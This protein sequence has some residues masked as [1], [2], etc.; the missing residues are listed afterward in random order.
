MAITPL[1]P[2]PNRVTDATQEIFSEKTAAFL[3]ALPTFGAELDDTADDVTAKATAAATSATNAA[4]SATAAATSAT[5]S[6]NSA[7]L[8]GNHA[9][10]TI[11]TGSAKDW[12]TKTSG[13]VVTGQGF[14][15]KKY[16]NDAAQS[17]IEAGALVEKY[18]GVSATD[19]T[20]DKTGGAL[21]AGDW[22]VN[23]VSGLIRAYTGTAWVNGIGTVA[24]VT[25]VAGRT[26][27][28]TLGISDVTGLQ[29]VN[30]STTQS[31]IYVNQKVSYEI[32]DYNSFSTY[33]V[34]MSAGSAS[35]VGST[36]QATM[37]ATAGM[38]TMTVIKDDIPTAFTISVQPSGV[39]TPINLTPSN[40][41]VDQNGTVTLTSSAFA[42]VG[43][44]DTHTSSN[45]QLATDSGFSNLIVNAIGYTINLTSRIVSGLVVSQ[46]Y[47][48][49]VKYTGANNGSSEWST[50]SS[51]TTKATLGGLIGEAG[52]QGFG[53]GECPTASWLTEL[54]LSA[55]VGTSDKASENYGNYQHTNGGVSVFIPKF[56]YKFGDTSDPAYGT[57]GANTIT[58]K[59]IETFSGEVAAN[60]AGYALHRAFI[61]GGIEKPGFFFDKYLASKD[62][63]NSCKSVKN[64]VP[65]SLTTDTSYTNSNGMT[66]CTGILADAVVLSRARGAG[67]N[68]E[69][70]FQSDALA[71]IALAHA[72][73]ATSTTY[74]AWYDATQTTNFPKGCNTSLK[75][76]NDAT[77]TFVSAGD[78][79][80][81]NKP[82]TGSASNLAKTTHNGQLCGVADVNGAM[83]Q[84][85]IGVTMAGTSGTDTA[86]NTTGTAYVLK[87][88]ALHKN[89]TG[90]WGGTT[91]AWGSTSSLTTNFDAI[92]GFEPWT[93]ATGWDYFGNGTAQVFSGATSGTDYLRSCSGIANLAGMSAAGTN[94]FGN[95]GSYRYGSANQ[96]PL[97]A[98]HWSD[99]A[100]AGVFFR[101][102]VVIRSFDNRLLGFRASAYGS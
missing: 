75:D 63:T 18:L 53:A 68:A 36:I 30:V 24:G 6:A 57:F 83:Y 41:A 22:Y 69:L 77:V 44:T 7:T 2:A 87:R 49:R 9:S 99:A 79:G 29:T 47:Y 91:D 60:A 80:D 39:S 3:T 37:P 64:G 55:M 76:V 45:W 28:V 73:H 13:E 86:Q 92:T 59:G 71:K 52:T 56:Y 54:G 4:N 81:A 84:A 20:T 66:G 89:L 94:Q 16:A 51:F 12:A 33:V 93:S 42:W 23:T 74:C 96:V 85:L 10:G 19:P 14:G 26:G 40:G 35:I 43:V 17:A 95:D 98:G 97:A 65:I 82:K 70:I 21:T 58:I 62:G 38:V 88:T 32:T 8:S 78:A 27:D 34:Q 61:D 100:T 102:W 46:T 5:N 90:G 11:A 25:S 31:S 72:Q 1:P 50:P 101:Y 67:W 15:A 48:W